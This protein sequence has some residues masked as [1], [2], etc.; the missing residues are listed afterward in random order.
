M[1]YKKIDMTDAT[2]RRNVFAIWDEAQERFVKDKDDLMVNTR[3]DWLKYG[4]KDRSI[5][6]V[7]AVTEWLNK[8]A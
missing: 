3:T 6:R 4:I 2:G 8:R 7:I 5:C 1:T